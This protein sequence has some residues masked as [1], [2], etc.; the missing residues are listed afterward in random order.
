[1]IINISSSKKEFYTY[2]FEKS[3]TLINKLITGGG[4]AKARLKGAEFEIDFL[5]ASN[6]PEHLKELKEKIKWSVYKYEAIEHNGKINI[7]SF[8]MSISGI[9]NSTAAKIIADIYS[10]HLQVAHLEMIY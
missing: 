1:M 2:F 5:L 8:Q 3:S 7:S 10:L 9:R 6:V 4:D